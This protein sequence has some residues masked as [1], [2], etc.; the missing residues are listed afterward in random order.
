MTEELW[1]D[2]PV[3]SSK[4]LPPDARLMETIGRN[5]MLE[6]AL[7]DLV[8]NSVDAFAKHVLVRFIQR[9]PKL[10]SLVVVDDGIGMTDAVIDK[11]MTVGGQGDYDDRA[12]GHFGI[13]LKAAALG[14]A[15]AL[16][17]ASRA[18]TVAVGR[19]WL[20]EKASHGFECDVVD[21]GFAAAMLDR[22]WGFVTP[23]SGTV[24][25]LDD[26]RDFPTASGNA[27]TERYLDKT[28]R[29]IR[30]HLGLVFH[31]LIEDSTVAIAVDVE[32]VDTG[33]TGAPFIVEPVNPF[34]YMRSG[35]P[36]YPKELSVR[37]GSK[38][39]ALQC[40]IWPGRSQLPAYK[41]PGKTVE[42]H[43]GFYFYRHNRLLQAGGWNTVAHA[44]K[45]LQLARVAVDITDDLADVFTMNPEK[46][47]VQTTPE[48][49]RAVEAAATNDFTF[50]GYLEAAGNAQKEASKRNAA[51]ARVMPPGKGLAPKVKNAI[52]RELEFLTGKDPIDIRW[53]DFEDDSF[54]DVDLDEPAIWLNKRYRW[55]VI[56]ERDSSLNDAPLV[57]ALLFLLAEKL[58]HGEYLGSR[59]RDNL[60][61]WNEI[62]GAAARVELE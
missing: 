3:T 42:T 21:H 9:G 1:D 8:D 48:F 50:A 41:L 47:R 49:T 28:T 33:E 32:D 39:I 35:V 27:V 2:V 29:E 36:G 46:T 10:T 52:G 15:K 44:D 5:H 19:R 7:A 45:S 17:V 57:K 13:G 43:Q 24:V 59:D 20:V 55:A 62:L 37:L 16:T 11:A 6:T 18:G 54:F 34:G 40:H 38:R 51:R 22:D 23:V 53:V 30:H 4:T 56:G 58:F 31:R 61:L 12:L 14:Q 26:L 25:R 60:D